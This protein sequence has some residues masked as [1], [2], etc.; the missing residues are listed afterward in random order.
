MIE[1]PPEEWVLLESVTEYETGWY[2]GGYDLYRQPD[3]SEKRYYWARLSPAVVVVARDGDELVM[4]EQFRPPIGQFDLE[5]PAG[6]VDTMDCAEPVERADTPGG[7]TETATIEPAAYETAAR[8]ELREETGLVADE[9]TF[10]EDSW[11]ATGLLTHQRGYVFASDLEP[12]ERELDPNEFI[13]VRKIPIEDAL[14]V[15]RE[16]PSNGATIQGLL[17]A[18]HEGLL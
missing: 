7:L 16:N 12:T 5:L 17:L 4:V 15:A 18:D 3:G 10:L 9:T 1:K 2:T 6:I 13:T 11:I 14:T 8:R